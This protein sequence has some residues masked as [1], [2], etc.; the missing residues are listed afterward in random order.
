M[1]KRKTFRP[2]NTKQPLHIVLRSDRA[3][4]KLALVNHQANIL[5][6]ISKMAARFQ[7]SVY[8][9]NINYNHIHL[10]IRGKR[11][12]NLQDFFRSIAALIARKVTRARKGKPYGTFWSYLLYSRVVSGRKKDFENVRNYIVQNTLETLGIIPYQRRKTEKSN[13][14]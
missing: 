8:E 2:V 7:I 6:I 11:R 5:K 10:L 1:G 14:S 3:K 12:K 9:K 4:Q 13:T